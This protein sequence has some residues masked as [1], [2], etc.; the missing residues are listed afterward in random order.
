MTSYKQACGALLALSLMSSTAFA[1]DSVRLR[2]DWSWWAGQT[3]MILAEEKGFYDEVDL[4]VDIVQGQGSK[5]T[6][7]VVGENADPIGHANLSTVAQSISAGVPITAVAGW[8]QQGPISL[9]CTDPNIKTPADVKGKRIGSTPTGSD[10]QIL[11]AF[12]M[13]NGLELTDISLVNM[14]GDAKFAG[15]A[16][17]QLDCI[18]GDDYFYGPQL[19][20]QGKEVSILK[21]ADWGVTNL[22]F[23]IV[24]N[25]DYLSQNPEIVKRFLAAT[26]KGLEYT[27]ANKDEAV[28]IFLKV[29]GNT[30]PAEFHRGVLDAYEA[31][32]HTKGTE[33]KPIG[34]MAESDWESMNETLAQ[35]GSM[36]GKK[37]AAAY[38]SNDQLPQ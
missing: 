4:D 38:F 2:L 12:L 14:P 3:P 15:I 20:A 9:I 35:F 24:V 25:S 31:S 8:W 36:T 11:P 17:G 16:S 29:S 32:L 34:W 27:L 10:G 21:Y 18:S 19:K 1:A 30:Q 6:T 23:G 26:R 13:A 5:T 28:E 33:G 7:M 37:E 22:G